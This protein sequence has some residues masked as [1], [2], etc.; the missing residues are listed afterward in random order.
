MIQPVVYDRIMYANRRSR[1]LEGSDFLAEEIYLYF[2]KIWDGFHH[3][4]KPHI[5]LRK[6]IVDNYD[7]D[8]ADQLKLLQMKSE[9]KLIEHLKEK[10]YLQIRSFQV[11]EL[12]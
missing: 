8:T 5:D 2:L 3:Q 6:G 11:T 4:F 12:L 7:K 10:W 9:G 1:L